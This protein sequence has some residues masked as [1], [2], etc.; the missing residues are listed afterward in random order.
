MTRRRLYSLGRFTARGMACRG[1]CSCPSPRSAE[2]GDA[3]TR[4]TL[5]AER[6]GAGLP[7]D[8]AALAGLRGL[9][10]AQRLADRAAD[11][12]VVVRSVHD[13]ALGVDDDGRAARD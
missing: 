9:E 4:G 1:A 13:L 10:E 6:L 7:L 3:G 12:V 8:R 11:V 5:L 2:R